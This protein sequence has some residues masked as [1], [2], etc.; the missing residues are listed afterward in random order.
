M[1]NSIVISIQTPFPQETSAKE[2]QYTLSRGM[3]LLNDALTHNL[4]FVLLPEYFNVLGLPKEQ[5]YQAANSWKQLYDEI[6]ELAK[7]HN[8]YILLPMIVSDGTGKFFNRTFII[9]ENGTDSGYYDKTHLTISERESLKLTAGDELKCF[10]TRFGKIAIA[11]CYEIYFPQIFLTL[12]KQ[13]PKII[14][15]PS[16]QRSEHEMA[17]EILIKARAMDTQSY[18]VRSSFGQRIDQAWTK[19]K[20]FGQSCI[21]HPD[22]TILANAGH[23]EGYAIA[24]ISLPFVWKKPRCSGWPITAVH[25]Y[26]TEDSRDELY[27]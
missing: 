20:M 23:Y 6:N 2:H 13:S 5:I 8:S 16:L 19:D 18:I 22:G 1:D 4:A 3:E 27:K 24:S 21:V 15:L 7:Q 26:L 11:V 14:F 10:E 17:S 25:Q 12:R 9:D